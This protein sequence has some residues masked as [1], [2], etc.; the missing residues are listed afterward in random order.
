MIDRVARNGDCPDYRSAEKCESAANSEKGAAPPTPSRSASQDLGNIQSFKAKNSE[1]TSGEQSRHAASD[2]GPFAPARFPGRRALAPGPS[3]KR[4]ALEA[5]E[6]ATERF[7]NAQAELFNARLDAAGSAVA[8]TI[9]GAPRV[10]AGDARTELQIANVRELP[11]Q[12]SVH[13]TPDSFSAIAQKDPSYFARATLDADSMLHVQDVTRSVDQ[14]GREYRVAG[15]NTPDFISKALLHFDADQVQTIVWRWDRKGDGFEP[16]SRSVS[17][18]ISF[19]EAVE[20]TQTGQ[21]LLQAGFRVIHTEVAALHLSDAGPVYDAIDLRWE[22]TDT[23]LSPPA[24]RRNRPPNPS[25]DIDLDAI[26]ELPPEERA[27]ALREA[28]TTLVGHS[29]EGASAPLEFDACTPEVAQFIADT[30]SVPIT[31]TGTLLNGQPAV[32]LPRG[33]FKAGSSLDELAWKARFW[34]TRHSLPPTGF[35]FDRESGHPDVPDWMQVLADRTGAPVSWPRAKP[36]WGDEETATPRRFAGGSLDGTPDARYD[37]STMLLM[38]KLPGEFD[39]PIDYESRNALGS[40][41]SIECLRETE[42][43]LVAINSDLIARGSPQRVQRIA[44]YDESDAHSRALAQAIAD[45]YGA[46]LEVAIGAAVEQHRAFIAGRDG[47]TAEMRHGS[48]TIRYEPRMRYSAVSG[49][50]RDFANH[51]RENA[52]LSSAG[53]VIH[54]DSLPSSWANKK[55]AALQTLSDM[56]NVPVALARFE[57]G[58]PSAVIDGEALGGTLSKEPKLYRDELRFVPQAGR[59]PDTSAARASTLP[60]TLAIGA[61]RNGV[62][63]SRLDTRQVW[64]SALGQITSVIEELDVQL[65]ETS[66]TLAQARPA[67]DAAGEQATQ[68]EQLKTKARQEWTD[69]QIDVAISQW[70]AHFPE[71]IFGPID[72]N[73]RAR[74]ERWVRHR[75]GTLDAKSGINETMKELFEAAMSANEDERKRLFGAFMAAIR[76]DTAA[77]VA[78]DNLE[79]HRINSYEA[80][81]VSLREAWECAQ[82]AKQAV[83]QALNA[84]ASVSDLP[85]TIETDSLAE[86]LATRADRALTQL[87]Q[88]LNAIPEMQGDARES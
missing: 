81:I 50:V 63:D 21:R 55:E 80:R 3:G 30:I 67:V 5:G 11:L 79:P 58:E 7:A 62:N 85:R 37:D 56:L 32:Y 16:F 68:A 64:K 66:L 43:K 83:E 57:D 8:A 72:D 4:A 47:I 19:R 39:L 76:A 10:S 41:S 54:P 1:Q 71:E 73:F 29:S 20:L 82:Q 74:V 17:E 88:A 2:G 61:A 18:G 40:A 13:R 26:A 87:Y 69:W 60:R 15:L 46:V 75:P 36:F 45:Q 84:V 22:K 14:T 33:L 35:T 12:P 48:E 52:V 27:A 51:L 31:V 59:R 34:M 25:R 86:E 44:A 9:S 78:L 28:I 53:I 65:R 70:R 6:K 24:H 77:Q 49:S 42:K 23:P 38:A